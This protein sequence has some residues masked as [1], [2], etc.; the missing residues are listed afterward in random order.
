MN[1]LKIVKFKV[2]TDNPD[3]LTSITYAPQNN[4]EHKG[5]Y[6][7][8]NLNKDAI[9]LAETTIKQNGVYSFAKDDY[10]GV[11]TVIVDVPIEI[12]TLKTYVAE[13]NKPLQIVTRKDIIGDDADNVGDITIPNSLLQD[14]GEVMLLEDAQ[15]ITPNSEIYYG[16][17]RVLIPSINSHLILPQNNELI[18][19]YRVSDKCEIDEIIGLYGTDAMYIFPKN[20]IS[21][22]YHKKYGFKCIHIPNT[23]LQYKMVRITSATEKTII[24]PDDGFFGLSAVSIPPINSMLEEKKVTL[25]KDGKFNIVPSEDF[26]GM[27][28]VEVTTNIN[29][30][31]VFIA[32]IVE[33]NNNY[34][35][36]FTPKTNKN[37]DN[38]MYQLAA[39][40]FRDTNYRFICL[41]NELNEYDSYWCFSSY[42][43]NNNF[44]V[45]LSRSNNVPTEYLTIE[46]AESD[47]QTILSM[48]KHCYFLQEYSSVIS[49]FISD[50]TIEEE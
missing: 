25:I 38:I 37:I 16:I 32:S 12:G 1:N 44:E 47:L 30:I 11:S 4:G 24:S 19:S 5:E 15:N 27:S 45:F 28:S 40:S 7:T 21:G 26:V 17:S 31:P 43:L 41:S 8:V 20:D 33:I 10:S 18:T 2:K 29:E 50:L 36:K 49:D 3:I 9:I 48:Q 42:S 23:K 14:K 22:D 39:T 35:I 6:I 13:L 46:E 34:Y